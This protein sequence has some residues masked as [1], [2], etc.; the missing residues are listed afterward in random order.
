MST[1]ILSVCVAAALAVGGPIPTIAAAPAP[2]PTTV[3]PAPAPAEPAPAPA[4][5]PAPEAA[6]APAPA[7]AP[8]EAAPAPAFPI[9]QLEPSPS[10]SAAAPPA[11]SP[12]PPRPAPVSRTGDVLI[13]TGAIAMALGGVSLL[14]IAAP[15]GMVRNTALRRA[16]RD[17]ALAFSSRRDRYDRARRSDDVMEAAFWIGAPLVVGGTVL[18]IAGLVTRNRAREASRIAAV[19][20]GLGVRF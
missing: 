4:P 17:D 8:A 12:P 11:P 5:A 7:P 19:P 13:T 20:G 14:F 18:L 16:E 1:S 9:E 2:G 3:A 15:A 6:P 10:P